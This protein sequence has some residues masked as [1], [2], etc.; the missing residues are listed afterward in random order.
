[1]YKRNINFYNI[2]TLLELDNKEIEILIGIRGAGAL[3]KLQ[4]Y[5]L[6]EYEEELRQAVAICNDFKIS[7]EAFFKIDFI[8]KYA[9]DLNDNSNKLHSQEYST[10]LVYNDIYKR[11]NNKYLACRPL[12]QDILNNIKGVYGYLS[13]VFDYDIIKEIDDQIKPNYKDVK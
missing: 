2:N 4:K 5:I 12:L 6:N 1:M 8:K 11:Y 9:Y 10:Q 3:L 13:K 7:Y